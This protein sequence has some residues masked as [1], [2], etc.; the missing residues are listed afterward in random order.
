MAELVQLLIRAFTSV[1]DD[2]GYLNLVSYGNRLNPTYLPSVRVWS[3]PDIFGEKELSEAPMYGSK[4]QRQRSISLKL[5]AEETGSHCS[6]DYF[7]CQRNA[8]IAAAVSWYP[9]Y[10][11]VLMSFME[12]MHS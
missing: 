6:F 9:F 10:A 12:K 1:T 2:A 8:P 4:F 3:I 7:H 5:N 11:P